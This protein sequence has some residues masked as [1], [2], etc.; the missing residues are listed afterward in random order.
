MKLLDYTDYEE[1]S[2]S[3]A[4]VVQKFLEKS[5]DS[6]KKYTIALSGGNSPAG[7]YEKLALVDT[8]WSRVCFFIVD[9]RKVRPE[10]PESNY[11]MIREK[12]LSQITIPEKN[13]YPVNVSYRTVEDCALAYEEKI[14]AF[15]NGSQ[16]VFDLVILGI[17]TDGHTASLF[18]GRP[19]LEEKKRI[20]IPAHA[21][22]RYK[23]RE[24]VTLT[25]PVINRA[26]HRIF[27]VSGSSKS[28]VVKGVLKG[29]SLYPASRVKEDSLVFTDFK[30]PVR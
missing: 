21:P 17:G 15:F 16:V 19:E 13:I 26:Q 10:N 3:A 1:M 7:F 29:D 2:T 28:S 24:R 11:R 6:I 9:E 25:F 22:D 14:K 4:A 23:T 12:L 20:A 27:I 8:N 30:I 18:P 5:K